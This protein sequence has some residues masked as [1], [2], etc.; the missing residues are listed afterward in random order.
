MTNTITDSLS[1]WSAIVRGAAVKGLE[2]D[3]RQR[4]QNRKCR[5]SYGTVEMSP[6][7]NGKHKVVDKVW[8]PYTGIWYA[9]RQMEWLVQKGQDLSTASKSH[10][11][12]SM[13]YRFFPQEKREV[14]L[15]L[16]ATDAD[17]APHRSIAKVSSRFILQTAC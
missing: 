2:G 13:V 6:F 8:E 9:D 1:R 5:R 12:F 7:V 14:Y 15:E 16:R 17:R 3:G 11:K 4:I 10:A